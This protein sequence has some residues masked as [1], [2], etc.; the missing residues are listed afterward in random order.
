MKGKKKK[1]KGI[2]AHFEREL[3]IGGERHFE[4][5][6]STTTCSSTAT[7]HFSSLL[8]FWKRTRERSYRVI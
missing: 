3:R 6:L 2:N 4:R 7:R 5:H 1:L 8:G